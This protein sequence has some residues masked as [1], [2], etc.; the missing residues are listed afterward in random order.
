MSVE[1]IGWGEQGNAICNT[2]GTNWLITH[3]QPPAGVQLMR[4]WILYEQPQDFV[5]GRVLL[6]HK[7][8]G[9]LVVVEE[10]L[11]GKDP[12]EHFTHL[13]DDGTVPNEEILGVE[14]MVD[15][16]DPHDSGAFEYI[17]FASNAEICQF[18][19]W[20]WKDFAEHGPIHIDD[21]LRDFW[22]DVVPRLEKGKGQ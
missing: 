10:C 8:Y 18:Y 1:H 16:N 22:Q 20:T 7:R 11:Q 2:C 17:A 19:D 6:R 14:G 9:F 4:D 12:K 13:Y 3:P 21:A 15:F 5:P